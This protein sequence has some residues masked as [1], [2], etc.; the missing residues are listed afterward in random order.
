V[1]LGSIEVDRPLDLRRTLALLGGYFRPDG[2]WRPLRTPEG[3]ATVHIRRSGSV[4]ESRVFGPGAS[5]GLALVPGF[6]GA[7]DDPALFVTDHPLVAPL[8]RQHPG[9]RLARTGLVFEALLSAIVAQKVTGKEAARGGRALGRRFSEPA[10]GPEELPL[11]PDPE[12]LAEAPYFEYHPLGIEQR[13][14]DTIR[15]AAKEA[16]RIDELAARSASEARSYLERLPGI[17]LWTSA[18]TVAISHGDADA[19]SV[20]D[21]HLKHIVAWHLTGRPRG[22]D[23]EMLALLEPFRPHRGRV[24]RLLETLGHEPS[25]GPRRPLRSIATN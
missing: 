10:P 1:E 6:I 7:D 2:W 9:W 13:R 24:V 23:Q 20:G 15:R 19:V 22:T 17:G 14:A 21:F 8:A 4:V 18:E 25:F 5:S 12:R 16:T 11:P 3:P